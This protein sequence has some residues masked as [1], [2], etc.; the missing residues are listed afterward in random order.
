MSGV[1]NR[2]AGAL[3]VDPSSLEQLAHRIA[4]LEASTGAGLDAQTTALR[5]A[6][7]DL[8]ERLA[9]IERRLDALESAGG[10]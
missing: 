1:R 10:A 7:A 9:A 6:T 8:A 3:G 5:D 2:V 4:E